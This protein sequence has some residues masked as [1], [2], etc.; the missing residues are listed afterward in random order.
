MCTAVPYDA[1]NAFM[2]ADV[3]SS[4]FCQ[5]TVK[6][7]KDNSN[8]RCAQGVP[9]KPRF[10]ARCII[11]RGEGEGGRGSKKCDLSHGNG[12]DPLHHI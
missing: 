11:G 2:N 4:Y 10:P 9:A 1:E 6:T 7:R 5:S 8:R 3:N 12:V